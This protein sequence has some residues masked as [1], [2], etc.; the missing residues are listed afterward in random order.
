MQ[1]EEIQKNQK[2]MKQERDTIQINKG[3]HWFSEKTNQI[4]QTPA[5]FIKIKTVKKIKT[6]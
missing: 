6:F 2:L 4:D 5:K 3:K 1:L